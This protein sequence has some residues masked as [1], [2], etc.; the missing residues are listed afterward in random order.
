MESGKWATYNANSIRARL[1][2]M[3]EWLKRERPR[4]VF[5]QETKVQ[6]KDFPSAAFEE[7]GYRSVFRGQKAYNG[8]AILSE[9]PLT[10]VSFD[11]P[12]KDMT[13]ARFISARAGDLRLINVYVP[14]GFSP[15]TEKFQYKLGWMRALLSF[16]K[17]HCM[18]DEFLLV[19][20]DFNVALEP[21][22]VYDPEGL[23]GQVGFHPEEQAI[24]KQ[25]IEWGLVDI[26]RM[27]HPGERDL[28]TFWDY[29]IPNGFKRRMGWRIDYLLAT[30]P[31]FE[32]TTGCWI[33]DKSRTLAQPSDHAF[34][35]A[36]ML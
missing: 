33:D 4:G 23:R 18:P 16:L 9:E 3:V 21:M 30:R 7:I 12:G 10:D 22:D 17:N 25:I 27:H 36:A 24:M 8:V 2:L 15:G 31:V 26:L 5:V 32:K 6:D 35:I 1:P 19:G 14:Q 11:G 13:D 29:R 34:L 28:Y 20:G